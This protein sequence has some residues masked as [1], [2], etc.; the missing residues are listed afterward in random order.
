[1]IFWTSA[2]KVWPSPWNLCSSHHSETING[3]CFIL[4]GYINL[5]GD[6][7]TIGLF[8]PFGLWPSH[9]DSYL[10]NLDD[11]HLPHLIQASTHKLYMVTISYCQGRSIWYE[12]C[13]LS[14]NFDLLTF[15]I[16]NMTFTLNFSSDHYT[17]TINSNCFIFTG[18]IHLPLELCTAGLFWPLELDITFTV[19]ILS[20]S[21]LENYKWQM[22]HI[23]KAYQTKETRK[24]FDQ[25]NMELAHSHFDL[26]D[27]CPWNCDFWLWNLVQHSPHGCICY[28]AS[29]IRD[30]VNGTTHCTL[31]KNR[32]ISN[33]AL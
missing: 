1:M 8:W 15:H 25:T 3:N 13:T 23:F 21:L 17:E 20:G 31:S 30:S 12:T 26:F 24:I 16:K 27:W 11:L 28:V 14:D 6:L 5:P 29:N 22:L 19:K 4:S 9:Y 7:C 2:L 32:L 18:H 33:Y 10:E